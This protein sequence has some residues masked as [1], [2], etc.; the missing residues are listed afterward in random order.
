MNKQSKYL[1]KN[2]SISGLPGAGSS[3]LGKALAE[4]LGWEYYCGGDFM[5]QEAL[6]RGK[7]KNKNVHHDA[8]MY[9]DDFD[10]KVDFRLRSAAAEKSGQVLESWLSGFM[11]QGVK[12]VLKVLVVCSEDAVRIDRIVNRDEITIEEAKKHVFEREQKNLQ[13]WQRM[14]K[15]QWQEWVIERG[16]ASSD[17]PIFFWYPQLYDLVL[18]TYS[19]NKEETLQNVL[20]KLIGE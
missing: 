18:D 16:K 17:K 9:D 13:K 1:Y 15:D 11:V 8:T 14:Y 6:A 5:R 19:L 10:R 2:V 12:G 3:T 20:D 7:L 4:K